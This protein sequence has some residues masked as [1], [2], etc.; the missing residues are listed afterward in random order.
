[1]SAD[2]PEPDHGEIQELLGAY[3]LDA[4]DPA[5][6][7][8]VERHLDSCPR[9]STE[10]ARH[11]EVAGLLANSG[12]ESPPEL[13]DGIAARLEGSAPPWE[14]LAA[15]LESTGEH[16]PGPGGPDRPARRTRAQRWVTAG[17]AV[18]AAAAAVVAI[19]LGVRVNHL[20]H[21]VSALTSPAGLSAAERE[22]LAASST[23]KV[24][25]TAPTGSASPDTVMVVLTVSGTGFVQVHR[26]PVLPADRT[27]QLWGVIGG[28]TISLG[29]LGH[30]P[31]VVPFSVAGNAPVR[32]F[33]ITDEHGGGVVQTSQQPVVAGTVQA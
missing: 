16:T 3:A 5:T 8:M 32:A 28:Q 18:V 21:Q 13:W 33:A 14:R 26:L 27:Y 24:Q 15:R 4:V 2:V 11:H 7:A 20:D 1:V 17:A 10:V 12:G 31:T 23:R 22:A 6:A 25:L 30:A 9:C 19:V 29:L